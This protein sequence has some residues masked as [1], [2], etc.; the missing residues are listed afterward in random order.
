MPHVT[1]LRSDDPR[2]VG[3][4]RF[5]GRVSGFAAGDEG[6]SDVFAAQRPDGG[7]VMVTLLGTD[8]AADAAD[9]DRFTAEAR[10]ARRIPPF[11]AA[12]I[13]DAGFEGM[14]PYLVTEFVTGPSL[15]EVVEREGPLRPD[16]VVALAIACITGIAAIHQAGLVHGQFA[17]DMVVLSREGPQVIHFS[18]TPPYGTATPAAD[19]L[20]WARTILFASTEHTGAGG[21]EVDDPDLD[22]LPEELREV[23]AD[24]LAPDPSAR[25]TARAVLTDLLSSHDVSAGLLAEGSRLGRAAA[26]IPV[27]GAPPPTTAPSRRPARYRMALWATACVACV[28]AIVA[29]AVYIARLHSGPPVAITLT[30]VAPAGTGSNHGAATPS[31]RDSAPGVSV[32]ARLAGTWAGTVRQT[33]PVLAASVRISLA[34]GTAPGTILYP[35][36]GCAGRLT[37]LAVGQD[38][39]TMDQTITSG[40]NCSDGK[41]TLA[42]QPGGKARFTFL[43]TGGSSPT[44]MLTRQP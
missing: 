23:M 13:L 17:P 39:L 1:P 36:L 31:G 24:C 18:I 33:D 2:R 20:A 30:P 25:P 15:E 29:A 21:P 37:V 9:R 5:T 32:P 8:Q 4:Y 27:A 43:R 42:E 7:T 19:V 26:R 10:A 40:K 6:T 34:A 12:R 3:R 11:C 22:A 41:I 28:A 38:T 44:G 14:R 16:T 35:Q